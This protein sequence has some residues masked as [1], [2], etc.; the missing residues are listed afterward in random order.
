MSEDMTGSEFM[1]QLLLML[2][3][4]TFAIGALFVVDSVTDGYTERAGQQTCEAEYG[5]AAEYIGQ[6][7]AFGGN[8]VCQVDGEQYQVDI[9]Y[10]GVPLLPPGTVPI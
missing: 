7:S 10:G 5:P 9:D 6:T 1:A 8:G 4:V 2:L 3:L